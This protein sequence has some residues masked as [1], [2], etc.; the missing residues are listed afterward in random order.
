MSIDMT[1]FMSYLLS[2]ASS[3]FNSL[4]P[5]FGLLLGITVGIG[6]LYMVYRLLSGLFPTH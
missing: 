6:L 2:T 1:L 4:I 5:I 3:F